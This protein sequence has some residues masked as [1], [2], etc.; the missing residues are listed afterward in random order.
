ME[1]IS[2]FL[3]L[4]DFLVL[5]EEFL[6]LSVKELQLYLLIFELL[7]DFFLQALMLILK[8]IMDKLQIL[9]SCN[10]SCFF[11]V[12]LLD[13]V[14]HDEFSLFFLLESLLE[15]IPLNIQFLNFINQHLILM[16]QSF[17]LV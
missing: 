10:D 9:Q 16:L 15:C 4:N 6:D 1:V 13:L 5:F 7:W 3:K 2:I 11:E 14:D 17:N 12:Q 8:T